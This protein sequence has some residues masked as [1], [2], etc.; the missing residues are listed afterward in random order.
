[1]TVELPVT[2]QAIVLAAEQGYTADL[3]RGIIYGPSQRALQIKCHGKQKYPTIM[4]HVRGL[5]KRSYTVHAHKFI[6]YLLWGKAALQGRQAHVRHLNLPTTDLR[7]ENLKLG[8]ARENEMDKPAHVRQASARTARAAQGK[9]AV[10][11]EANR[12]R[13]HNGTAWTVRANSPRRCKGVGAANT[14]PARLQ[15]ALSEKEKHG[16][17]RS[18]T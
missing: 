2:R 9:D 5:P 11:R 4:L 14:A 1:M 3:D 16:I 8:T 10:Q 18:R 7:R 15:S 13:R 12:S 17:D 6:G